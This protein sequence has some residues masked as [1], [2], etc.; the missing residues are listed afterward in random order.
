MSK[1]NILRK[2]MYVS[3]L[4]GL[5]QVFFSN[6]YTEHTVNNE[7][8]NIKNLKKRN[9]PIINTLQCLV[10]ILVNGRCHFSHERKILY[11][12]TTSECF[13]HTSMKIIF[14]QVGFNIFPTTTNVPSKFD[15][16]YCQTK[17]YNCT[18]I[19]YL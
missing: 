6:Y 2:K 3:A 9:L 16:Y 8:L 10:C 15:I 14:A 18:K 7:W 13:S 17:Y 4:Y 19:V 1:Q 11:F 5:F 12:E